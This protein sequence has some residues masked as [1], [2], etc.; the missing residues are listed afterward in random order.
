M[1]GLTN[2]NTAINAYNQ[3]SKG[4]GAKSEGDT[5]GVGGD[6][7]SGLVRNAI[8]E[9]IKI[10]EQSENLSIAAIQDKADLGQVVT[11]VA[12]AE[13][14]LQTVVAVRDKMIEAY[15]EITRMPM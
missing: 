4:P 9:A 10:G 6:E 3:T 5:Q 11:A 7:F 12:E 14:A 2:M 8:Q 15:R 13:V 1:P